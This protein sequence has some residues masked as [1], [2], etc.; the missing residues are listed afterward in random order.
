LFFK[1]TK[2]DIYTSPR[3]GE[4][5]ADGY[6]IYSRDSNGNILIKPIGKVGDHYSGIT[7]LINSVEI[8]AQ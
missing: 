8:L 5:T 2:V 4:E 6:K 7:E 3:S 1:T